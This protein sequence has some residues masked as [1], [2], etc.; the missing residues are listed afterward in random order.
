[1]TPDIP[2]LQYAV[3][4]TLTL[5]IEVPI[6]AAGLRRWYRVELGHGALLGAVA[7]LLTHPIVWFVLPS[8]LLPEFG[9]LGYLAVAEAFAWATEAGLFWLA[10]RR[11]LPGMLLLSLVAN[12]TSFALG[13]ALHRLLVG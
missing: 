5:A 7:S 4:L 1:M 6:V 3:A 2:A 11:D 10:A 13:T 8:L 9:L 12:L